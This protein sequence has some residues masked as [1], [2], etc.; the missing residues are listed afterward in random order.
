MLSTV[1]GQH[2]TGVV[3]GVR[4]PA[5]QEC[6]PRVPQLTTDPPVLRTAML[7]APP[8]PLTS[9]AFRDPTSTEI[10]A[11]QSN[12][13]APPSLTAIPV[14]PS[15]TPVPDATPGGSPHRSS[16]VRDATRQADSASQARVEANPEIPVDFTPWWQNGALSP[17]RTPTP[18]I[19]LSLE[20]ALIG[21]LQHSTQVRMIADGPVIRQESI[22]Q[23]Q[24]RFDIR[25]FAESKFSDSDDPVGNTLT[26]GGAN[27]YLDRNAYYSGGVRKLNDLGGQFELSEKYGY[28]DTN[29]IYFTPAPQGTA[30]LNL[31]YTQPLLNGAG[32]AYNNHLIVLAQLDTGIAQDQFSKDLQ[33]L[34]VDVHRSYWNLYLQRSSLLQRRRLY[35]EAVEIRNELHARREVDVVASQTARAQAAMALRE[36]SVIR[37]E[38]AVRNAESKMVAIM[39]DPQLMGDRPLELLPAESPARPAPKVDLNYSL[40]EALQFRPEISQ[41][42]KE[43]HAAGVRA[44]VSKNELLPVLNVVLG[45]YVYGLRGEADIGQA[46]VDQFGAGRPSYSAGLVFEMP[47]G[48]RAANSKM[49]QRQLEMR[50]ATS[51]LQTTTAQIRAEV[52]IASREVTTSYREMQSKYQAMIAEEAQIKFLSERWRLLPGDQQV[53]G[54]ILEDLL[55]AQDRRAD[56]ELGMANAQVAYVVSQ[57]NLKRATGTLL[58]C[59]RIT[60][61]QICVD[62]LPTLS[63][64]KAPGAP[65]GVAVPQSLPP[66]TPSNVYP[67]VEARRELSPRK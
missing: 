49:T 1:R 6:P 5:S 37:Q 60:V 20:N 34:L 22:C 53:A 32:K 13:P 57:V 11:R 45:T 54:V 44:D 26:T 55:A 51:L 50:Q 65:D 25:T 67:N 36:A 63:V 62:K 64:N 28:E 35:Q 41:A 43:I 58:N 16:A 9:G 15:L 56:A 29:S 47:W 48:N 12:L 21:T 61:T 31:S 24:A 14:G 42:A 10:P 52:E 27:R 2:I 4:A 3:G 17:L 18:P 38:T 66:A 19:R 33:E 59:E 30:R 40:I 46:W 23:E 39:H 8:A 7:P